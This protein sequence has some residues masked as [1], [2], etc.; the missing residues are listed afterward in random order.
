MTSHIQG[1]YIFKAD[2]G[3]TLYSRRTLGIEE[4]L[5]SAFLSALNGLFCCFSLGGISTFASENFIVYLA[6]ANNVLTSLIVDNDHKSDKYFN[7]AYEIGNQY[8]KKFASSIDKKTSIMAPPK[9]QFDGLLDQIISNFDKFSV[10]QQEIIKL[11]KIN[12]NGDLEI[13]EFLDE[14][15]LYSQS[16][17]IAVNYI[18]KQIFIIEN[19]DSNVSSRQLF[20]ANKAISAMNQRD[21][22]SEFTIR[23][24][25][26][27][28]DF[29]RVVGQITRLLKRESF[30]S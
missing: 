7:L 3:I 29:E 14:K 1:V 5:F 30:N 28:W 16:M 27:P 11:F 18:T 20:L 8:Y 24:V 21:L 13:F 9:D 22:K 17:F 12:S 6:S 15:Q 23:Q 10:E 26:D 2:S 4:D 19:V 25:S